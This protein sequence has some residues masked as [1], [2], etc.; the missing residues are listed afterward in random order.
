MRLALAAIVD[1][2]QTLAF[3]I[4]EIE[5]Q[6]AVA[7]DDLADLHARLGQALA[8]ILE[9]AA[10]GDAQAGARNRVVAGLA[11]HGAEIEEGEIA[12]GR[13]FPV[14][15]E[16]VIGADIVLVD[17]L[18]DQAHAERLGIESDI[19]RRIG[20]HSRQMMDTGQFHD[21][22]IGHPVRGELLGPLYE[23]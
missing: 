12:A 14:G 4:L 17:G 21:T 18:L 20:G 2:R 19:A 3:R 11:R 10:A 9:A 16:E 8:P 22:P 1:E 13:G 23:G 6:P 7:L 15:I 5:R